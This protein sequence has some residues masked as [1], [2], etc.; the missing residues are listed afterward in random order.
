MLDVAYLANILDTAD[1]IEK[2]VIRRGGKKKNLNLFFRFGLFENLSDGG[3][4]SRKNK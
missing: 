1:K 2:G 3:T 4:T